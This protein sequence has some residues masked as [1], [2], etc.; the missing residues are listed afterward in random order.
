[1]NAN[2]SVPELF[3]D[4]VG[5]MSTLFRSEMQLVKA[6]ASEKAHQATGA[7]VYLAAGAII[8]L[9]AL[10]A[11]LASAVAWLVLMGVEVQWSTLIVAGVVG[12]IGFILLRKGMSDLKARNLAPNRTIQ[13]FRR[14]A[15]T[16]REQIR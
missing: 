5:H 16:A 1:M 4:L 11:L 3:S 6:E 10:H 13:Q 9:A 7:I 12:L 2:R 14:D 8:L 15:H